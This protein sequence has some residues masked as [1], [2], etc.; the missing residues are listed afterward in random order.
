MKKLSN[1]GF[2]MIE[3][4]IVIA[5]IGL[6][7]VVLIPKVLPLKD[8][9]KNN[10]VEANVFIVRSFLE[11]RVGADKINIVSSLKTDSSTSN[12]LNP[13]KDDIGLKMNTTF[14][15]S[16]AMKNPFNNATK[17]DK[18]SAN[19]ALN[20]NLG[21]SSVIIGYDITSIPTSDS[22]IT[23]TVTTPGVTVIIVYETGYVVYGVD[24]FGGIVKPTIINMPDTVATLPAI[25]NP[26]TPQVVAPTF[27]YTFDSKGGSYTLSCVQTDAEIRYT[28]DGSQPDSSPSI[29]YTVPIK[30]EKT[31]IIK[32]YATYVGFRD[33]N[34]ASTTFT[35]PITPSLLPTPSFSFSGNFGVEN[36]IA[37][38]AVVIFSIAVTPSDLGGEM[39]VTVNGAEIKDVD[40]NYTFTAPNGNKK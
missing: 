32:A 4:M 15:G 30:V 21:S 37:K 34:V 6:L 31:T 10:A 16:S 38:K 29:P 11:N 7:S 23:N 13:I 33:S 26:P 35:L 27:N 24:N 20:T 3:L 22:S 17:I 18:S 40:G 39:I 2:T 28:I 19:V 25:T 36:I 12:A 9:A 5:V 8:A 14:S 1:K